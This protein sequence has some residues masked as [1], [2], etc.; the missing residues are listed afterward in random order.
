MITE[1]SGQCQ[2]ENCTEAATSIACGRH[3]HADV[4]CYCD[5][6]ADLVVD[7]N[8]PEYHENCPNCGCRFGV[9]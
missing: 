3:Y 8:C 1:V 4:G 6:H 5:K 9:N 2:Y 7:E